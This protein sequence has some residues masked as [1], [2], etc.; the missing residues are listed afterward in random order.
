MNHNAANALLKTLEEPNDGLL[1]ILVSH[2]PARLLPTLRS[3]CQALFCTAPEPTQA[4][5]WLQQFV[6]AERAKTALAITQQAPL[7]AL[8]AIAEDHDVLYQ[9]VSALLDSC[10]QKP[11]SYLSVAE[12]LAKHDAVMIM[13]WWMALLRKKITSHPLASYFRFYDALQDARRKA[14]STA[15]PNTR[16]LFEALLIDWIALSD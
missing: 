8:I 1:I 10:Q 5:S 16:M 2:Q 6:S 11:S 3:R 9:N 14:M 15:N 12:S 13:E 7:M 4:L